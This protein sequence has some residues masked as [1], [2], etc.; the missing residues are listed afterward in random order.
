MIDEGR[1]ESLWVL[2]REISVL[3]RRIRRVV[4]ERARAVHPQMQPASYML[5]AHLA[6]RGPMRS[7]ELADLFTVDKGAISRQVQHLADLGL[8]ERTPDPQDG[9]AVLVAATAD[10][11]A[12]I[13]ENTRERLGWLDQRLG[14][15]SDAQLAD[16]AGLLTG[17]NAMLIEPLAPPATPHGQPAAAGSPAVPG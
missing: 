8:V 11:I 1:A 3:V 6:G 2:E 12:R 9:R 5:L 10:A 13:R 14:E 7:S 16:F 15:W 17:Y 4:S